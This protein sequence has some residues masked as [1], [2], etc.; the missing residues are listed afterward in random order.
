[1][2]GLIDYKKLSDVKIPK[3]K[4]SKSKKAK[5]DA[6]TMERDTRL[7]RVNILDTD[8]ENGSVK[9]SYIGYGNEYNEWRPSEDIVDLI[10]D[11]DNGESSSS[12]KNDFADVEETT[13]PMSMPSQQFCLYN[14]LAFRIK[15][16]LISNRKADPLC[17][18]LITFDKL[19]YDGLL[20]RGVPVKKHACKEVY[21]VTSLSKLDDILGERWYIRGI[22]AAGDF[23]FVKPGSVRYFMKCCQGQKDYQIQSDGSLKIFTFGNRYQLTFSFIREDGTLSQWYT[24][25]KL[26]KT[27]VRL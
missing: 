19:C 10:N 3:Q 9:V 17:K 25:L 21:T 5:I 2:A 22:N 27:D 16:L 12:T 18:I 11:T 6:D 14:E 7:F 24:T 26:C 20:Y 23:S 4:R 13:V 8:E 15:S 1:M